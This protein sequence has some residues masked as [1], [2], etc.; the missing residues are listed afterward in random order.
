M[1]ET[2]TPPCEVGSFILMGPMCGFYKTGR[3]RVCEWR[4]GCYTTAG[5]WSDWGLPATCYGAM[6]P[7]IQQMLVP[8]VMMHQRGDIF[9]LIGQASSQAEI[10]DMERDAELF[11]PRYTIMITPEWI[12]DLHPAN[13]YWSC[14]TL[15]DSATLGDVCA[16]R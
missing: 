11:G 6:R 16:A 10:N 4:P 9:L 1:T 5:I 3:H 8:Q 2:D 7:H 12:Q 13:D 15:V 14:Q